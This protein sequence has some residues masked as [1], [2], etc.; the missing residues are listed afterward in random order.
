[1]AYTVK[2]LLESN[3]F[4]DMKLVA[5]E[6][7]LDQEIKGIRIIEIEDME[8][9]LSGGELLLTSMKV[10]FGETARVFRK[11]LEK[12]EKKQISGF[13]I[14]RHPEIVQKVD[15]YTI[16][17]KFCSEREIPV[18]EIPEIEYYWEIIKYVILQI[19]DENIARLIYFKLT[20][21]NIS[22]ILLNGKN[23]EDTMK[24][25]LF[26]LSSMIGNPV[27]LYYSNL[28]CCASTTQDLSDFVF[29]KNVE[30]YKPNIIT[31]F[32]YQKQTKEHTQYITTINVLGRAEVYLVVTEMNMPLTVLD[33]MALENAVLTL[34]YSFME[35]YAQNEIDKKYQ[36]DVGYSLLNGLLTGD[37]LNK[38]AHMLKLKEAAQ[39]CVVSFHTI[40]N[41]S[42]DYYTK[43]ELEEI[44]VIEGEIQRLL[45][46]EHIYRNRNQI[47]CIHEIKP[48]ETQAGFREE[49]E[50][51]YDTIQKQIIHRNKTTDFQIGIGS[52]V[53]DLKKSFKDSKKII[54][55]MDMLRYLYGD[56]NISV[57]DFSKLGFFQIFEKIKNRDELMEYVPESL[58]KLYWYDKEHDGEL[59]ETLQAYLDCD[60][61]A[62][63]AAEKLYVNYR[64]LSGRLKKIKDISGIDFKNSAEMLAVRNGIVLFKMAETL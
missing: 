21:D 52:I 6:K 26:L 37:E 41:N 35:S 44:G 9:C 13:I 56:K 55:Y 47:V 62:N 4:P 63:K 40:S 38:A 57:A 61:S 23:F 12:L 17:L 3:Q 14:K 49:M 1:M 5:G 50:K 51:L 11:H 45:P 25:I 18:I 24:S 20:H 48:G 33:Y 2:K 7:S 15:Y 39:Y 30:K 53:N 8:R 46:D 32:E 42:E 36:R 31:R 60:K 22:N 64:T 19:Y 59:I 54:D 28:T 29:E 34:Q 43:E 10:Y 58:V 27:A 16:L